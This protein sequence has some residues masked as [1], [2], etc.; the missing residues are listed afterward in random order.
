MK[1][2][3]SLDK[4]ILATT[5]LS[6]AMFFLASEA[7]ALGLIA[8]MLIVLGFSLHTGRESR[9]ADAGAAKGF[10]LL[11]NALTLGVV[12]WAVIRV[13]GDRELLV[14]SV[15]DLL[16]WGLVIRVFDPR[17]TNR[18]GLLLLMS[19]FGAV[20]SILTS[21]ILLVGVLMAAYIPVAGWTILLHQF[22]RGHARAHGERATTTHLS[23]PREA[24]GQLRALCL[25][26]LPVCLFLALIVYFIMP[27]GVGADML[28]EWDPRADGATTGFTDRV[29]LQRSGQLASSEEPVMDLVVTDSDGRNIGA[30]DRPVL[31][32]GAVLDAYDPASF[33]WTRGDGAGPQALTRGSGV[34]RNEISRSRADAPTFTYRVTMRN[35]D[36]DYIFA[37]MRPVGLLLDRDTDLR[38]GSWDLVIR[39]EGRGG[40]FAYTIEATPEYVPQRFPGGALGPI[41]VSEAVAELAREILDRADFERDPSEELTELDGQIARAFETHFRRNGQYDTEMTP[42]PVGVD[43]IE[44][45][46]TVRMR[47]HCEQYASA[48]AAMLRS[49]GVS[50]RVVTGYRA[51]EY[52]D[53]A[54]HYTVRQRDAHAW[55]E[56]RTA[57]GVWMSYDPSPSLDGALGITQ[58]TGVLH[59]LRQAYEALEYYWVVYI[60]SFD[61]QMKRSVLARL[62]IVDDAEQRSSGGR[63]SN[64]WAPSALVPRLLRAF[65]AGMIV[66]AGTAAVLFL[67]SL[68]WRL[69]AGRLRL[70]A[71]SWGVLRALRVGAGRPGLAAIERRYATAQA[72]LARGGLDR[73]PWQGALDHSASL[74]PIDGALADAM[75]GLSS[76]YYRARFGRAEPGEREIADADRY[77]EQVAR[78]ARELRRERARPRT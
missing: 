38:V 35:K 44:H 37:P 66:F 29:L 54:G 17:P 47:G 52:N 1:F 69:L 28:G 41:V 72:A 60:V 70:P 13:S 53:L 14:E 45:F 51:H 76:L 75:T 5:L 21:N 49:L 33:S 15:G 39:A 67:A 7:T 25:R 26:L 46:L 30:S 4:W 57:P 73:A 27:R 23:V 77:L 31:L 64:P 65:G 22:A 20:A 74:R 9:P 10:V 50:A 58:R 16:A 24:I 3:R 8:C 68:G 6:T 78:R 59:R 34:G 42:S 55:V 2:H 56:V 40:R 71:L 19:V 63:R 48:M 61:E 32:R 12:G 11:L 18:R 36:T 62:G 43:P